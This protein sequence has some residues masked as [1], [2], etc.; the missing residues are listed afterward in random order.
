MSGKARGSPPGFNESEV[1]TGI[2]GFERKR[3]A[4]SGF[5]DW[6]RLGS[7]KRVV[8][9][10]EQE[11]GHTD[12]RDKRTGAASGPIV[13][14]IGKPVKTGGITVVEICEPMNAPNS[15]RIDNLWKNPGLGFDFS[16]EAANET[17]KVNPIGW[18]PVEDVRA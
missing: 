12:R 4:R 15:A 10:V 9:G 6:K 7:E 8:T 11:G 18:V 1:A 17:A 13:F 16:H 3:F 5:L 2:R 14:G